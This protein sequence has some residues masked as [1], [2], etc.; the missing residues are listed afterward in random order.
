MQATRSQAGAPLMVGFWRRGGLVPSLIFSVSAIGGG[1]GAVDIFDRVERGE[2][3]EAPPPC[4]LR[5][6]R[7]AATAMNLSCTSIMMRPK[8]RSDISITRSR[9][10]DRGGRISTI[11]TTNDNNITVDSHLRNGGREKLWGSECECEGGEAREAREARA[12]SN[13]VHDIQ[14]IFDI[15]EETGESN[16]GDGSGESS[17]IT[18]TTLTAVKATRTT[19]T[20]MCRVHYG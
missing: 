1:D 15:R 8:S 9:G 5:H 10:R 2:L 6:Q 12:R 19:T 14:R 20:T 7:V 11:T 3:E 16:G 18:P 13:V 17:I 4:R